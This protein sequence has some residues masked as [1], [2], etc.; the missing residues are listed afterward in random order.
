MSWFK[1]HVNWTYFFCIVLATIVMWLVIFNSTPQAGDDGSYGLRIYLDQS[2]SKEWGG[3]NLP[4]FEQLV[5]GPDATNGEMWE[6]ATFMTYLINTGKTSLQVNTQSYQDLTAVKPGWGVS[7]DTVTIKPGERSPIAIKL[8]HNKYITVSSPMVY[9]NIQPI[10]SDISWVVIIGYIVV[11]ALV[12]GWVLHQKGRS[13]G[14]LLLSLSGI[15]II[16]ILCLENKRNKPENLDKVN[17]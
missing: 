5:W 2:Y 1:R 13:Y 8:S 14:W 4:D 17:E 11:L 7:S 15:G 9:F 10:S 16:I 6:S 3:T 12:A